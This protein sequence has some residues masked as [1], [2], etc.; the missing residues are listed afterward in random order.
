MNITKSEAVTLVLHRDWKVNDYTGGFYDHT[1]TEAT[2]PAGTY[3]AQR[4]DLGPWPKVIVVKQ[5]EHVVGLK[6]SV[7]RAYSD[8]DLGEHHVEIIE[9]TT[10]KPAKLFRRLLRRR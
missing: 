3:T 7:W 9:A 6:D 5:G 8:P 2:L 10:P 4:L 1:A